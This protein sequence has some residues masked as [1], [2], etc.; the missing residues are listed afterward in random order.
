MDELQKGLN[1]FIT[2]PLVDTALERMR[3]TLGEWGLAMPAA[4][5]LVRDFG[6][7]DFWT[8]A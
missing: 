6:L 2:G 4:E 8:R 1:I 5:P 7:G 3:R